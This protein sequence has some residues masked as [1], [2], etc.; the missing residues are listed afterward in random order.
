MEITRPLFWYLQS[1]EICEW[2]WSAWSYS[3][4]TVTY[5]SNRRRTRACLREKGDCLISTILG[6]SD[7]TDSLG[8]GANANKSPDFNCFGTRNQNQQR[9][10]RLQNENVFKGHGYTCRGKAVLMLITAKVITKSKVWLKRGVPLPPSVAAK[11]ELTSRRP[12]EHEQHAKRL[13]VIAVA[14]A[15]KDGNSATLTWIAPTLRH[16]TTRVLIRI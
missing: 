3:V 14:A 1:P 5:W 8:V 12:C 10:W 15:M 16:F 2:M 13:D 9:S 7:F 6:S 11:R 4:I